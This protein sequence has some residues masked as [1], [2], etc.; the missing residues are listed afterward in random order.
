ML[1]TQDVG[2]EIAGCLLVTAGDN[3]Q[4]L[5]SEAGFATLYSVAPIPESP[6]KSQRHRLNGGGAAMVHDL[7]R[8]IRA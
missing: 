6:G 3:P 1:A 8:G 7:D 4:Q 2:T 5:R